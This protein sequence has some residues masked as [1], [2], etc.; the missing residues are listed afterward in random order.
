MCSPVQLQELR[1]ERH[2]PAEVD[3]IAH[4]EL[5]R[6]TADIAVERPRPDPGER[7][8]PRIAGTQARKCLHE[9]E[10]VLLAVDSTY[11]EE[12]QRPRPVARARGRDEVGVANL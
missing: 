4:P 3:A 7:E 9:E 6:T 11:G 12:L 8:R 5:L 2:E 1:P 10:R